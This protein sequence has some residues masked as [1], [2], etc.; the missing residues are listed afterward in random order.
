[1]P[2][3]FVAV[4]HPADAKHSLSQLAVLYM[5]GADRQV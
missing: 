4:N 3:D 5:T 1:M 2:A